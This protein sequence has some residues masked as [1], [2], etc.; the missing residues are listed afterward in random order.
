MTTVV[1]TPKMIL[2]DCRMTGTI[3]VTDAKGNEVSFQG[4]TNAFGK[5]G[6]WNISIDGVAS[7]AYGIFGDVEV[8]QALVGYIKAVGADDLDTKLKA[9][10]HFHLRLP[11]SNSGVAWLDEHGVMRWC[12]LNQTGYELGKATDKDYVVFGTGADLFRARMLEKQ[13]VMTAFLWAIKEDPQS[14]LEAYDRF[15]IEDG[16]TARFN[17]PGGDVP[18][19]LEALLAH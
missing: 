10:G 15:S 17:N 1:L 8:A 6:E 14:S 11:K 18:Q 16:V 13:D 5:I 19:A 9:L 3:K 2:A 12:Y 4:T 7:E